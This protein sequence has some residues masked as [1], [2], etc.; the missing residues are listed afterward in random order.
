MY[1][2]IFMLPQK[3]VKTIPK[4]LQPIQQQYKQC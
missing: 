4:N 3:R 2:V 1:K